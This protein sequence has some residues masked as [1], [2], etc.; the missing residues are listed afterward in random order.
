[1]RHSYWIQITLILFMG[2]AVVGQGASD[3][4]TIT[5]EKKK[6]PDGIVLDG[7]V[8][9]RHQA[10]VAAQVSGEIIE[11]NFDVNDFVEKGQV[12]LRF[13]DK[14]TAVGLSQTKAGVDEAD[15][16]VQQAR[17]EYERVKQLF[18]KQMATAARMDAAKAEM[19]AAESRLHSAKAA[20]SGAGEQLSDTVVRA[21][22]SGFVLKRFV[23]T[24]STAQMGQPLFT[25]LSLDTLR[26]KVAIP[27]S[28][29]H[30]LRQQGG[31][32][33]L[34]MGNGVTHKTNEFTLFPYADDATHT[35]TARIPLPDKMAGIFPGMLVKVAFVM[36][37]K[38]RL[39]IPEQAVVQRSEVTGVYVLGT[40]G[41]VQLRHVMTGRL[42]DDH[43]VEI[44]AGLTTGEKVILDPVQAGQKALATQGG[45]RP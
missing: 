20:V 36:G 40:G 3:L 5:T 45:V 23:E 33:I 8:E 11:V 39:L 4:H 22:Y 16:R 44:L 19:Q 24:G 18:D 14:K 10:T 37:E 13:R 34:T 35:V 41:V 21:P 38:E 1:M 27:Q 29:A 9:P 42:F 15:A 28:V 12:L 43:Q 2:G 30:R 6:T 7:V 17:N 25:G 32:A 26:V 31:Q